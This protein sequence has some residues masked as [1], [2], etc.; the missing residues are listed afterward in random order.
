MNADNAR[1]L[2]E[3]LHRV[4]GELG[5]VRVQIRATE[6]KEEYERAH[7]QFSLILMALI[8]AEHELLSDH[9][10][11]VQRSVEAAERAYPASSSGRPKE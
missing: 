7:E 5:R 2:A 8:E 3:T 9:P 6:S 4:M 1:F 11:I 10:E